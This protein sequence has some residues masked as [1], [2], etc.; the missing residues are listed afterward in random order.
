VAWNC[1]ADSFDVENP[2]TARNWLIGSVGAIASNNTAAVPPN[3]E[4]GTY[5]ANGT[6]VF[7]LT[8]WGNQCQD[9]LASSNLQ[10]REYVA[11]DFDRMAT[12]TSTGDAVSVDTSWSNSISSAAAAAG[13]AWGNFDDVRTNRWIPWTHSFTV[14]S[15][16]AIISATLSFAVRSTGGGWTNDDLRVEGTNNIVP[17]SSLG[18]S[19]LNA[20]NSTVLRCDL[21]NYLSALADGKLN[22]AVS[23]N[24]AVD[25]AMLELRVATASSGSYQTVTIVSEAD[26]YVQGGTSA[27]NTY[28]TNTSMLTKEASADTKR[29]AYVRW[30]FASVSNHIVEARIKLTTAS[31]S[32]NVIENCAAVDGNVWSESSMNWSNQPTAEAP[33]C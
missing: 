1:Q 17:L 14:D 20:S 26:T 6:N 33:F 3:P 5:D 31:A 32:T 22:L 28:G 19:S 30:N 7:P 25:W 23:D 15:K 8:L 16:D 4:F 27:T 24:T 9:A 21:Q 12:A 18:A 29:R 10:V 13:A 11:G 2:P